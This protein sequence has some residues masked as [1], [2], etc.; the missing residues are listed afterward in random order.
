QCAEPAKDRVASS[1]GSSQGLSGS[2]G[3]IAGSAS[4]P[5]R[6]R[7]ERD[8]KRRE[9]TS[10]S[11]RD[12]KTPELRTVAERK[13]PNDQECCRLKAIAGPGGNPTA[14]RKVSRRQHLPRQ[15]DLVRLLKKSGLATICC[16]RASQRP[17]HLLCQNTF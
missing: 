12:R 4:G 1:V 16:G 2:V 8:S 7:A 15:S 6:C 5:N 13:R 17:H 10:E 11:K 14:P 3:A 9:L